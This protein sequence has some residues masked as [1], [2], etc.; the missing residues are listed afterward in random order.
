MKNCMMY[1]SIAL[2][3][4]LS[5]G[6]TAADAQRPGPAAPTPA[7]AVE[8]DPDVIVVTAGQ[9]P[10]GSVVGDIK[11]EI[12]L[13]PAD[14]RSF[15]ASTITELLAAL[16][17]QTSSGRGGSPVTLLNGK[18]VSGFN[19]I[20][21]IP[22]EAIA[23]V[24]ILPEEVALKYGYTS[25]Q[26][27]VNIVLRQRFRAYS[28][29]MNIGGATE[30]GARLIQPE[31]TY[32]RVRKNGRLNIEIEYPIKSALFES[33]RNV[34]SA[35]SQYA[36]G[37]NVIDATGRVL[38]VL[39]SA[40]SHIPTL[41]DFSTP[42]NSTNVQPYRT[43]QPDSKTF[44]ANAVYSQ[45]A[46]GAASVTLNGRI[47]LADSTSDTGLPTLNLILPSGNPFSPF[48]NQTV[49]LLRYFSTFGPLTQHVKSAT[50]HLGL[51][52]NGDMS[53]SWHWSFTGNLDH[54]ESR[55][56]TQTGFASGTVAG[57]L[58]ANPGLN[59]FGPIDANILPLAAANQ[60]HA[61]STTG[62]MDMLINGALAKLPA[63]DLAVSFKIASQ[64]A[65]FDS[66]GQRGGLA[67]ANSHLSQTVGSGQV[68]L[69]VPVA[70][71][72]K[73]VLPA[74]GD[75]SLNGNFA[76][77]KFSGFG[78]LTT[79]G[80]GFTWSPVKPLSLI[81]AATNDHAAPSVSQLSNPLVITPNAQVFDPLTGMTESVTQISGGNPT[82]QASDRHVLKVEGEIQLSEKPDISLNATYTRT[83]TNNLISSPTLTQA[84]LAKT[85]DPL[86][87]TV[88]INTSPTNFARAEVEQFR[89]GLNFSKSLKSKAPVF[90]PGGRG[91]GAPS[92]DRPGGNRQDGGRPGGGGPAGRGGGFGQQGGRLQLAVY[93]T[94]YL[95]DTILTQLGQKPLNLLNGDT[96]GANGGQPRH[97][98]ELQSGYFNN[99]LGAR[100]SATWQSPTT[101]NGLTPS[102]TLHFGDSLTTSFR[103][104]ANL[105][106]IPGV[107]QKHPFLR[108]TRLLLVVTNIFN[109]RQNVVDGSGLTAL[110]Y[111]PAYLDPA[112]RT[113]R[114]AFRKLFF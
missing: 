65:I 81:V 8:D 74:L 40:A 3:L 71:R 47:D 59:P 55:T 19:E 2:V 37:G 99:G 114:I 82:L 69:D 93:H 70:S 106:N 9:K 17:P 110:S 10:R 98:I 108:G 102:G 53:G 54:A 49:N 63:G 57:L 45:S 90:T 28:A 89:W 60:A 75:L 29:E 6:P 1:R 16:A 64:K 51:S 94:L 88:T 76:A 56:V 67:F 62:A 30:G 43:L 15:G 105:G 33:E 41:T 107:A 22:P 96:S 48:T 104:F 61:V 73:G 42:P 35:S 95:H 84:F 25:D 7:P 27:V 11:P 21:D 52:V 91:G 12:Q 34:I 50:E 79:T 103:L 111:Q 86:T 85:V 58:A 46:L 13:G 23:R 4:I 72:R 39:P 38:S 78:T 80:Y 24:D 68:N 100:L 109:T 113:I 26:K 20:R 44:T 101:V 66:D 31:A 5:T 77:R 112:G 18:R 83:N 87:G 92:G 36:L 32:F 14:I 97:Q